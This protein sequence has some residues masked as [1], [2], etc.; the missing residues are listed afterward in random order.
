VIFATVGTHHQ[1]FP[2]MLDALRELDD[3]V[4]V[5]YGYNPRPRGFSRADAF[6]PF[7]ELLELLAAADGVVT[8]SGVGSILCAREAGHLPVVVPRLARLG[9][10]VDDHQSELTRALESRREVLALWDGSELT[11]L[12]GEAGPRG[13]RRSLV[14]TPLHGAVRKVLLG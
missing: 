14:E 1:P 8:H 10:H 3:D 9:E 2:R 5:Q 12:L 11:A 6:V 4:V 7:D 13:P